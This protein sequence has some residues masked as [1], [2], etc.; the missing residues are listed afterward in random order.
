[1]QREFRF[2]AKEAVHQLTVGEV[3]SVLKADG[4]QCWA[5]AID[6]FLTNALGVGA[7]AR[8]LVVAP[9]DAAR[10]CVKASAW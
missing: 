10:I 8:C 1:M 3:L 5:L 4:D 6:R 2:F 9:L 7:V